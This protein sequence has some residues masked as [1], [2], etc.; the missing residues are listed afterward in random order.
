MGE[1]QTGETA[2]PRRSAAGTSP[3][4]LVAGLLLL[5]SLAVGIASAVRLR[6]VEQAIERDNALGIRLE[7]VLSTMK[8]L[9]TGQRGFLL[10]GEDAY[11]GPYDAAN[12][13]IEAEL[14]TLAGLPL[15]LDQLRRLVAARRTAAAE[16]IDAFRSGGRASVAGGAVFDAGKAAMDALR[17]FVAEAQAGAQQRA[18]AL[19]TEA[20]H[21]IWPAAVA[22]GVGGVAAFALMALFAVRRRHEQ[23][24]VQSLLEGVLENAPIGLGLLDR[25]LRVRHMNRA[26]S[27]MS[28]R[29]LSV[30]VGASIWDVVPDLEDELGPRLRQ[31]IEAG[32]P[33]SDIEVH[34]ASNLR[35]G[36]VRDYQV[37]FFPIRSAGRTGGIDGAGMVVSD[38]TARRRAERRLRESE[39]RFRTLA[40]STAAIIWTTD[41]TGEFDRPQP[42]W[43]AFTGQSLEE[44]AGQR[45][46]EAVH[47]DDRAASAAA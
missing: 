25:G 42:R 11:L 35:K 44:A 28:D 31:V 36:Q 17:S 4:A 7:R 30:S 46:F 22:A 5:L 6:I 32:R 9:E 24:A 47:P 40:E 34:A 27:T 18:A 19:R 1:T 39:E 12:R 37:G 26:L 21:R 15:D 14:G 38:V 20:D 13:A 43:T 16:A 10:T 45:Y 33:A 2:R 8:D 3:L 23:R 41:A 29:A